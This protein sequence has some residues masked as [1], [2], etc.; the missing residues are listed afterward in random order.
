[1]R[2]L[3]LIILFSAMVASADDGDRFVKAYL[4]SPDECVVISEG[5]TT[6]NNVRLVVRSDK[7][8]S[9]A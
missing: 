9:L 7:I 1:M 6:D 5:D 4:V 2:I 3:I 8:I